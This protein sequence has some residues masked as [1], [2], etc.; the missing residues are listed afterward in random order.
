MAKNEIRK[1]FVKQSWIFNLE[2]M[3]DHL[4]CIIY[5]WEDGKVNFPIEIAGKTINDVDEIQELLDECCELEW[6][7]KCRKVT[8]KE[9]GRIKAIVEYR[10]MARYVRC[11]NS[12]MEERFAGECFAD[13]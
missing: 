3:H 13:M 7:A 11:L 9:Y 6:A 1:Y 5:D 8:G 4:W 2:S 12:G 10:V